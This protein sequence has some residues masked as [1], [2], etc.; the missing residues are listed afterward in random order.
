DLAASERAAMRATVVGITGST[1]KTCTK[2]FT[3]AVLGT[4][5]R[6]VRSQA[7][8]NNEIG[9]PLTVLS[10]PAGTEALVLEMV[11]RGPGQ[12]RPLCE[13]ARPSVGVVTNVGVAHLALFGSLEATR[14]AKAELPESLP[15]D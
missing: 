11:A 1:G 6:T 3:G 4:T 5:M 15:E 14:D 9:L 12:I 10:A 2:D 8:F 13:V 7:S